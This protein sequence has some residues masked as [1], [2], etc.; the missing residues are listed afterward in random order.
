MDTFS[1]DGTALYLE[2]HFV[3]EVQVRE[4]PVDHSVSRYAA[5]FLRAC[6]HEC[7]G[8]GKI[9]GP[10][11]GVLQQLRSIAKRLLKYPHLAQKQRNELEQFVRE[12][13]STLVQLVGNGIEITPPTRL[14]DYGNLPRDK[15]LTFLRLVE[16]EAAY[17]N[18]SELWKKISTGPWAYQEIRHP[19]LRGHLDAHEYFFLRQA[20]EFLAENVDHELA[21]EST[22]RALP[23]PK[24]KRGRPPQNEKAYRQICIEFVEHKMQLKPKDLVELRSLKGILDTFADP[25]AAVRKALYFGRKKGWIPRVRR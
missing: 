9:G 15:D 2:R 17:P 21:E 16:L 5:K 19:L 22:T 8:A 1:P 18:L 14:P 3:Y 7:Y 11:S 25:R 24:R 20:F 10:D 4:I 13:E 6:W 23:P 12:F